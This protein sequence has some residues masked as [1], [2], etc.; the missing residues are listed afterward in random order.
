MPNTNILEFDE[1]E[2]YGNG[3]SSLVGKTILGLAIDRYKTYLKFY[4]TEGVIIYE[5]EGD[6]CS[7]S[8]FEHISGI[9]D[10]VEYTDLGGVKVHKVNNLDEVRLLGTKQDVDKSY[11]V[12]IELE[13]PHRPIK[14]KY[15][16]SSNGYYGGSVKRVKSVPEDVVF[17]YLKE[18]L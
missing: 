9:D 16:N 13:D 17:R 14:I 10:V 11:G 6:C 3:F 7:E 15:R 4:T 8:W 1:D 12:E 18:D 2:E 5:A